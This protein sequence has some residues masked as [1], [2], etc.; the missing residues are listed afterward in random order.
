[1]AIKIQA[2]LTRFIALV[3]VLALSS[4]SFAQST[5]VG[6]WEPLYH[7]DSQERVRG[8]EIGD[9][10]GLPINEA[11]RM[12]ADTWEPSLPTMP[13]RQCIPHSSTY[14]FRGIGT[15]RIWETRDPETQ[16]L[17]RMD[18]LI[19][20]QSQHRVLWMDGRPD[21]SPY[22]PHTWQGFSRAH[23]YGNVL[24]VDT[25]HLKSSYVKRNGLPRS[26]RATMKEYF[27]RHG[28]ILTHVSIVSDPIYLTEPL[29]RS[30]NFRYS[31]SATTIPYPCRPTVEVVR[32]PG[33]IPH[34]LPGQNPF[35]HEYAN[36]HHV[37]FAATRGG[38]PTS[39]PDYA[40]ALST[41]VPNSTH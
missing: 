3:S 21:L 10:A 40:Y 7:E 15:L 28:E 37:P 25:D 26:D 33:F 19:T 17:L 14:G 8:P 39:L 32:P 27:F 23:W 18:T 4:G 34:Y 2:K 24:V 35:L 41:P 38:A 20:W 6:Y 12:R 31:L 5:L 30:D 16:Q 29:V 9:Y 1:M 13:E 22:A 36:A 11:A